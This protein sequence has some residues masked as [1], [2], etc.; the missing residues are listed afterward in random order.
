MW[1]ENADHGGFVY[2]GDKPLY[3]GRVTDPATCGLAHVLKML[4][5]KGKLAT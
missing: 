3:V 4:R 1:H 2:C 5:D